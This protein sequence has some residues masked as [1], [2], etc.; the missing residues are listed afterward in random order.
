VLKIRGRGRLG[1]TIDLV[2]DIHG[3]Q[4]SGTAGG[5]RTGQSWMERSVG[6]DVCS[7]GS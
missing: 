4:V 3:Q 6:C 5:D 1:R 2:K 7:C